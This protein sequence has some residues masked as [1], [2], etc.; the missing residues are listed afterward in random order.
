MNVEVGGGA[1]AL[2]RRDGAAVTFV[3]LEPGAAPQ[4][5][6]DQALH[7]L[8]HQRDQFRLRG[9]QQTQRYRRRQHPLLHRNMWDDVVHQVRRSLRHAPGPARRAKAPPFAAEGEQL[10]VAAVGA[11]TVAGRTGPRTSSG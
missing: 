11:R 1:K 10:V 6:R 2:D 5:A 9:Q 3:G 8:Q 4:T 7:H